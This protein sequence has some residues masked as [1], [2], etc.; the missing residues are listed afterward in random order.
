VSG[1]ADLEPERYVPHRLHGADR[2]FAETNCYVDV[3]IELLH[4]HQLE[5]TAM[6][7]FC[8]AIDWEGDQWTFFK[9]PHAD[10]E[11]LYGVEIEELSVYRQL[12]DHIDVLL[13]SGRTTIVEVDAFWLPDV[14][15]RA[16]GIVH[17][18]TSIAP[19]AIDI[20]ARRLRYFHNGGLFELQGDDFDAV[21][22]TAAAPPAPGV[23]PGYAELVK[24]ERLRRRD[25][26]E[27]RRIARGLLSRHTARLPQRNP[28]T[29]FAE[30]LDAD[31]P[32][33]YGDVEAYHA[34]AFATLRQCGAAWS[35]LAE[36]LGWLGQG[37]A[38]AGRAEALADGS[39][40][41]LMK[42]ARATRSGRPLDPSALA[43]M[44]GGWDALAAELQRLGAADRVA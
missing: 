22:H 11:A 34:Y 12:A 41:L 35:M 43:E 38:A 23:L 17:E 18:K 14:A 24:L 29:A 5:P 1:L 44:A 19:S 42:L 16:Y 9:P 21:L 7:A 10:L 2:L 13:R 31:L 25:N 32:G 6:L 40:V 37:T 33:L 4:A 20:A 39:R 27:L 8:A 28:V 30:Q 26:R 15:G 36:F 3:W